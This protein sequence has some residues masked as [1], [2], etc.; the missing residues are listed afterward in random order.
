MIAKRINRCLFFLSFFFLAQSNAPAQIIK[1]K[2]FGFMAGLVI[3][4]GT[5]VNQVGVFAR[6]YWIFLDRIQW[7]NDFRVSYY[8]RYLGPRQPHP[9]IHLAS[10]ILLSYGSERNTELRVL[11][12]TSNQTIYRNAIAYSYNAYFNRIGT[13]QQTGSLTFHI[14]NFFITHENDL[15]ARPLLDRFRTAAIQI[16]YQRE[17]FRIALTQSNWTGRLRGCIRDSLYPSRSGYLDTTG[18]VCPLLSH[19][20]LFVSAEY[21]EQEFFQQLKAEAGIDAEQIRHFVQ[22]K[23]VHDAVFLPR[24]W[25]NPNNFHFPM[26]DDK[27]KQY[28]FRPDQKIR[29]P[30][31]Y[32]QISANTDIIY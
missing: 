7:N 6:T 32:T 21:A 11:N 16:G 10:G 26:I 9:E 5:H 22:N 4:A 3:S 2:N 14:D 31:I 15:L 1:E 28:L 13:T 23:L 20:L 8:F 25:R 30:R 19:G 24:A 17:N 29:K 18:G 27:G 12:K